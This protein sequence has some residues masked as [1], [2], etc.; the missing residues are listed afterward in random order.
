[1]RRYSAIQRGGAKGLV[2]VYRGPFR[3]LRFLYEAEPY[4]TCPYPPLELDHLG[5]H[6]ARQEDI[7]VV[8]PC[9]RK[10]ALRYMKIHLK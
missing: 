2:R 5:Q 3:L 4:I 9:Y 1:M 6:S 10:V 8:L 7:T